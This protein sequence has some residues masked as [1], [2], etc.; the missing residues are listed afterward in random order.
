MV[1]LTL[2]IRILARIADSHFESFFFNYYWIMTVTEADLE[3]RTSFV[4]LFIALLNVLILLGL[5]LIYFLNKKN[6]PITIR[7]Y[8]SSRS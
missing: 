1:H 7:H 5:M 4:F 8:S 6:D 2:P 3:I